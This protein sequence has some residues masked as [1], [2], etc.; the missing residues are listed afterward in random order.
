VLEANQFR[1]EG[2]LREHVR[3]GGTAVD[4]LIHGCLQDER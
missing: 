1:L 2:R 3:I 4:S